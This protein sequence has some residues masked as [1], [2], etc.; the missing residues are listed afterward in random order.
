MAQE[1]YKNDATLH[2]IW[3]VAIADKVTN[4]DNLYTTEE[5]QF[6]NRINS[7]ENINMIWSDFNAKRNALGSKEKIIE[8][9]CKALRGC[10]KEWK[11]K[12][13]GYMIRM[14]QISRENDLTNNISDKEWQLILGVSKS[15]GLTDEERNNSYQNLIDG[16]IKSK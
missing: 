2:L 9:A 12:T 10:G 3:C 7:L 6:M 4:G 16:R 5:D 14:A 8:E 11:I 15:L 13:I 1:M